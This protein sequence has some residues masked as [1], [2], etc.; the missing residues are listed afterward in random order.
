MGYSQSA[1]NVCTLCKNGFYLSGANCLKHSAL[2]NCTTYDAVTSNKCSACEKNFF[3]FIPQ[4][5]CVKANVIEKCS[6][7]QDVLNC[8]VCQDGFKLTTTTPKRCERI[9]S[10]S[11]CLQVDA[12]SPNTCVKCQVGYYLKAGLCISPYQIFTTHCEVNNAN[13]LISESVL[14]CQYCKPNALPW[15]YKNAYICA[16]KSRFDQTKSCNR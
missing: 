7:N 3:L 2:N 4:T 6:Q 1:A 8:A 16:S 11:F 5:T 14:A 9:T 13:G 12:N 15:N 10:P